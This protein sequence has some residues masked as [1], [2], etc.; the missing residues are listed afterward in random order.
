[1]KTAQAILVVVLAG[2]LAGCVVRAKQSANNTPPPPQP[3]AKTEPVAAQPQ[4]LSIPQTQVELPPPQRV[5]AEATAAARPPDEAVEP[6]AAPVA[7]STTGTRRSTAATTTPHTET[8]APT[9]PP[10]ANPP[11]AAAPPETNPRIQEIVSPTEQKRLQDLAEARKKDARQLLDQAGTRKLN[12]RETGLK[13][14][15]E[16][17]LKLC[18]QAEGKGDMRQA[19]D[20][21]DRAL[22][23]AKDLQ[24]GR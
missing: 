8:P 5:S 14:S 17:F 18:D 9:T 1:M 19:A 11:A 3:A 6:A 23:L 22:T 7:R 12:R 16:S 24:S 13:R 15:I 20:Y 4:P 2:T 10:A 21:A